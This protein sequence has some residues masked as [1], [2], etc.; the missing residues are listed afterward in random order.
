MKHSYVLVAAAL[1]AFTAPMLSAQA[2]P[3]SQHIG[4]DELRAAITPAQGAPAG[5][6]VAK[7]VCDHGHYTCIAL[8]RTATGEAELHEAWDDVILVQAGS[9]TLV[10]GGELHGA[11]TTAAGELRGGEIHGGERQP[12]VAGDLMLVQAGT[13]HQ[14]ELAAGGSINYLVIKV[15]RPAAAPR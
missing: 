1:V 14:V 12:L 6:L 5:P 8:R 15:Q 4:Q 13:P 9:G 11:R 7:L 2:S 10:V 3:R